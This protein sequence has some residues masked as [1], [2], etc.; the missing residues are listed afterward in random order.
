MIFNVIPE[1]FFNPLTSKNKV[2][3]S[4]CIFLLYN[5]MNSQL[6]FGV[7]REVVIEIIQDYL[8]DNEELYIEEE[9][10]EVNNRERANIILRKLIECSWLNIETTNS[11]VQIVSFNDYA[12]EI[13]KT[14][15]NIM[16]NKKLEYE[17]YII[18]IYALVKNQALTDKGILVTQIYENTEKLITG[19]K[20]LNSNIKKYIDELTKHSTVKEIMDVLL[21]DYRENIADKAYHRLKTSENV[22]KYRPEIRERLFDFLADEIFL[23]EASEKISE[24]EEVDIEEGLRKA[25]TY[26]TNV[27]EAFD[28]IDDIIIEI[29]RKNSQY[30]RS[31]INRAK[32]MLSNT[33]DLSGQIK[34]ILQYIINEGKENQLNYKWIYEME[35]IE[36]LFTMY[37]QFF[38][39][40]NSLKEPIEGKK[41]FIPNEIDDVVID[42]ELRKEK[43]RKIANKIESAMSF[44][45][46]EKE[47]ISILKDKEAVK[48]S[49]LNFEDEKQL[50]KIIYIRLYGNRLNAKYKIKPL[51][52]KVNI[53]GF[54]FND[55]EIW[56]K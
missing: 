44:K 12:I 6:S 17:G 1:K 23:K 21:N 3:Y 37:N 56:R 30:Q 40:D 9:N 2:V 7:E 5:T 52:S 51:N 31:A 54:T 19:L 15:Q 34:T 29:D 32:F 10:D 18:T 16:N 35:L 33:E 24:M 28:N 13:T 11:Y 41:E 4:D 43:L 22:S 26:I 45:N 42:E 25:K 53:N 38:V 47:V 46:I 36:E 14:L 27:L 49:T 39:D 55:Y 20:T 50:M 48:V 8:N